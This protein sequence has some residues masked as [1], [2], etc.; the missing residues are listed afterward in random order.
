M[1]VDDGAA[2]RF[3]VL[4][5]REK[6]VPVLGSRRTPGVVPTDLFLT[7]VH[8]VLVENDGQIEIRVRPR[9]AVR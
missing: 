4:V 9:T 8:T 3:V 6:L 5:G 1:S 7:M 2:R